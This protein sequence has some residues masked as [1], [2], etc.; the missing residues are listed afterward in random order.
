[1]ARGKGRW[2]WDDNEPAAAPAPPPPP[3][4]VKVRRPGHLAYGGPTEAE[5]SEDAFPSWKLNGWEIVE[6]GA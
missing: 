6:E 3:R 1:M 2:S 5:I 4:M